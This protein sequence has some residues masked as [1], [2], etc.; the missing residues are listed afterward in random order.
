MKLR[1]NNKFTEKK[2]KSAEQWNA[3]KGERRYGNKNI[4]REHFIMIIIFRRRENL[5]RMNDLCL[6]VLHGAARCSPKKHLSD[7]ENRLNFIL[8]SQ[9]E[10]LLSCLL[11]MFASEAE[12]GWRRNGG[13]RRGLSS[14]NFKFFGS[15]SYRAVHSL[16]SVRGIICSD[17]TSTSHGN[18]PTRSRHC[19]S[20]DGIGGE[21]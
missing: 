12:R 1:R 14:K 10:Y 7:S 3:C 16:P 11:L 9:S 17:E 4:T 21:I 20:I 6:N 13:R 15:L 18:F 19:R 5:R 2:F 8:P